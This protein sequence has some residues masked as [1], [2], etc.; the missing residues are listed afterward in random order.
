M[1]SLANPEATQNSPIKLALEWN[2]SDDICAI[3]EIW[4]DLP[5]WG[6]LN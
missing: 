3:C 1:T 5:D 2:A 4:G 6:L